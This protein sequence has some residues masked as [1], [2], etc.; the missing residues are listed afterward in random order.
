MNKRIA[1]VLGLG[2]F[3]SL[4]L[5]IASAQEEIPTFLPKE[6]PSQENAQMELI[7]EL[8]SVLDTV[9]PFLRQLSFFVGGIFGLYLILIIARVYYERKTVK[10]LKDIRYDLDRL[11]MHYGLSCSQHKKGWFRR[12]IGIFKRRSY[13]KELYKA[14][15]NKAG[16]DQEHSHQGPKPKK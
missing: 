15:N 11:N 16:D 5:P 14:S 10:I 6:G 9:S 2:L 13:D 3:L 7:P 8:Q 1:L 12:M 4:L